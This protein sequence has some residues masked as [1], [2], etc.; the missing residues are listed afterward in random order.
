MS[1]ITNADF[2]KAIF[3]GLNDIFQTARNLYPDEYTEF[4]YKWESDKNREEY[5]GFVPT[6]LAAKKPEGQSTKIDAMEQGFVNSVNNVSYGLG[7]QITREARDDNNY[8]KI[9]AARAGAL[10]KSFRV[11]K[12]TVAANMIDRGYNPAYVGADGVSLFNSAHLTKAGLTQS[13]T[14]AVASDLNEAAIEQALTDIGQ[15]E[16]ERGKREMCMGRKLIVP[17]ALQ[18]EA[19]RILDSELQ[20]DTSNNAVNAIKQKSAMPGGY[21]VNHYLEDSDAWFI[22]TD[23]TEQGEGLIYQERTAMEFTN[24]SDFLTD[25]AQFKGYERYA[26]SWND[27]R[28]AYGS[29]GA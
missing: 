22:V 24:D 26:F 5:L 13:N 7:F 8:P 3:P 16:D 28:G 19:C 29:P 2:A 14:L 17:T 21:A 1:T 11:T 12:E 18:W 6:G 20:N 25:N 15:F 4:T 27:W 9:A 10:G 23:V